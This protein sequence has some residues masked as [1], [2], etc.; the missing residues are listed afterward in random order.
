[1]DHNEANRRAHELMEPINQALM[2]CDDR[3]DLL[4]LC[5]AMMNRSKEVLDKEL[6]QIRRKNLFSEF[7]E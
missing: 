6:G 3:N 4:I 2:M 1:M 7:S 5:F